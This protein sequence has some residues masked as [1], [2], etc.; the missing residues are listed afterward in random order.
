MSSVA[1]QTGDRRQS[2]TIQGPWASSPLSRYSAYDLLA[3]A[4]RERVFMAGVFVVIAALGLVAAL[5]IKTLYPA[6][7]SLLVRLGSEYVYDPRVGDAARGAVPENDQVI[8]SEIEILSSPV[9]KAKVIADIGL[10]RL[11]PKLGRAYDQASPARREVIEGQAI[12]AIDSGL[13][14]TTAPDTSV[15]RLTYAHPDPQMAALVLNTLIDEYLKYRPSVLV[16]Q[17]AGVIGGE[18][19]AFQTRLDAA[20]AAYEK[21]LADNG[22]GDFDSEKTS[23]GAI[24][25]QLLTDS[26]SVQAQLSEAEGRLG[27]TQQEVRSAAPEIGLY[28]DVD[29]TASDKLIQLR[30]DRQDLLS[31]YKP[32]ALPVKDADR[33]I[34]E[35]EALAASGQASGAGARRVGVNPVYQTLETERNQL[36][37][38]AASLRD[39]RAALAAEIAQVNQRRQRLTE[40]EPQYQNLVRNREV[41]AANVRSFDAREQESQAQQAIAQSGDSNVRVVERALV[42]TQGSNLRKPVLLA[43]LAFA[44][45]TALCA[46]LLRGLMRRSYPTAAAAERAL[47][48]P[49]L[50]SAP[51]KAA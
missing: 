22:I 10:D 20:D 19:S 32:D 29:H 1:F 25:S 8:Q 9:L 34:A 28:R 37:A 6:R 36:A 42:P 41:L 30:I 3:A 12:K 7:S 51:L 35:L 33:R 11:F 15:V 46:G 14:V 44:A 2:P 13:K 39:R 26:Y 16:A 49:V 5:Q 17:D 4:W 50:A 43:A 24:Y 47:D 23:L 27:V 18:R 40:L 45:F 21:F 48:L 38:Q 31:R